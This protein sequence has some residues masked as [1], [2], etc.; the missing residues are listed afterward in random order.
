MKIAAFT[1]LLML[2]AASAAEPVPGTASGAMRLR[3]SDDAIRTAVRETL[4]DSPA[5]AP[6]GKESALRGETARY[7]AFARQVGEARTPSCWTPDGLKH[8]PPRIGPVALGGVLA[9]PFLGAAILR[10]KCTP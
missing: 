9:L 5:P 2:G 10:G 8:Q 1:S 3:L 7:G 6:A 4:A